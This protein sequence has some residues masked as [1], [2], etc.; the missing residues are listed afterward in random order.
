MRDKETAEAAPALS[1]TAVDRLNFSAA[2]ER[3]IYRRLDMLSDFEMTLGAI[4]AV[5]L[6]Y[7]AV[8]F[9]IGLLVLDRWLGVRRG[10]TLDTLLVL[11]VALSA[12]AW[13]AGTR[14]R[15]RLL[16]DPAAHTEITQMTRCINR[17]VG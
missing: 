9:V 10:I 2:I 4:T 11:I 8:A 17:T 14:F 1:L 12:A 6:D 15:R 16:R 7:A 5:I 3:L 13:F